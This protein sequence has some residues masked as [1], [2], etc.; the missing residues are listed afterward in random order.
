MSDNENKFL[1]I[2]V[3]G[4]DE[5]LWAKLRPKLIEAIESL[6]DFEIDAENHTSIKVEA[7]KMVSSLLDNV[8][9]RLNKPGIEN[10]KILA[11]I[12]ETYTRKQKTVAETR[13]INAE[14]DSI[15]VKN[16]IRKLKLKLAAIELAIKIGN[17]G[18]EGLII[19][20]QIENFRN[21]LSVLEEERDDYA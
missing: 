8:K 15:E 1:K 10:Q 2:E 17:P 3:G 7:Q 4:K 12:D 13:K 18:E 20:K 16:K 6:L 14:A 5:G 19:M 11:E 9:S 21:A